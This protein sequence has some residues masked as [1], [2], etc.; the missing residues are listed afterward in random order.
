MPRWHKGQKG[1]G[2]HLFAAGFL[3]VFGCGTQVIHTPMPR[4]SS[5][6]PPSPRVI[7]VRRPIEGVAMALVFEVGTGDAPGLAALAAHSVA[8]GYEGVEA[9]VLPEITLFTTWCDVPKECIE[10]LHLVMR[11][12][13]PTP[14][15]IEQARSM[16]IGRRNIAIASPHLQAER[17][18]IEGAT[19]IEL[20]PFGDGIN[21][22]KEEIEKF[23]EKNYGGGPV[24]WVGVGEGEGGRVIEEIAKVEFQHRGGGSGRNSEGRKGARRGVSEPIRIEAHFREGSWALALRLPNAASAWGWFEAWRR[25]MEWF[26]ELSLRVFPLRTGW[27]VALSGPEGKGR[28]AEP[29]F[30]LGAW[31]WPGHR[32]WPGPGPSDAMELME[33]VAME[34][35]HSD[36]H[37]DEQGAAWRRAG[38]AYVG[39][40]A[41]QIPPRLEPQPPPWRDAVQVPVPDAEKGVI[42]WAL[43]GALAEGQRERGATAVA[44]EVL[45]R[46]CATEGKVLLGADA[47]LV[48]WEGTPELILAEVSFAA[49]CVAMSEPALQEIEAA[50]AALLARMGP[51]EVRLGLAAEALLA[52]QAARIA[53]HGLPESIA[54]LLPEQVL[55]KWRSWRGAGRWAVAGPFVSEFKGG[56]PVEGA[57][58][59]QARPFR[60]HWPFRRIQGEPPQLIRIAAIPDCDAEEVGM[61]LARILARRGLEQGASIRWQSSGAA[62]GLAWGAIAFEGSPGVLEKLAA[63]ELEEEDV[64]LVRQEAQ[65]ARQRWRSR[66]ADLGE[67]ARRALFG[68]F[69]ERCEGLLLQA[70][71]WLLPA[72]SEETDPQPRAKNSSS[73]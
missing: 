28:G 1:L 35:L 48:V 25:R 60:G 10:R 21:A 69:F 45:A 19:G 17:L 38:W 41:F 6:R 24:V 26:S 29:G 57:S 34:W 51:D 52:E 2:Y 16:L 40:N 15:L 14:H 66:L 72:L 7:W 5:L 31:P 3:V 43:P 33:R 68:P 13:S 18:A 32:E 42:L 49:D 11:S 20:D 56:A 70:Q 30:W 23:I 36:E 71:A 46:R 47:L 4:P 63:T 55:A 22:P 62:S 37:T 59:G 9:R 53:P 64:Q 8:M 61:S 39:P 44:A 73:G 67:I 54:R 27:V 50:R 12:G 58:L 65:K